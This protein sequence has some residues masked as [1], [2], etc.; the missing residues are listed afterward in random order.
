MKS[1]KE[2]L[3]AKLENGWSIHVGPG[4]DW[5]WGGYVRVCDEHGR[6]VLYEDREEWRLDPELVMGAIFNCAINK[7]HK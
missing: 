4:K 1:P 7:L 5:Q 2:E 3:V 6:E